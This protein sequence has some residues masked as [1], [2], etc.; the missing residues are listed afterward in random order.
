[1][2]GSIAAIP[3]MHAL[4][5]TAMLAAGDA[6]DLAKYRGVMVVGLGILLFLFLLFTYVSGGSNSHRPDSHVLG[7]Q[8]SLPFD[9]EGGSHRP[10]STIVTAAGSGDVGLVR[11]WLSDPRCVV[12]ACAHADGTSALH[13]AARAGHVNI[14]RLLLEAGA[15]ALAVDAE[16]RTPLHLVAMEGHGLCVK[17]LLDAGSDPDGRDADGRTPLE[18]AERAKNLGCLRMMRLHAA[19]QLGASAAGGASH[20]RAAA[21]LEGGG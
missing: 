7:R 19:Q 8:H 18:L 16:L 12:D 10:V 6:G 4:P 21:P 14:L 9:V 5:H 2:P 11:E 20:R 13:A 3:H 15:D 1:M 17:C